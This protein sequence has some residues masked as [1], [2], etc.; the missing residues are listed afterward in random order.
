MSFL[1]TMAPAGSMSNG[2]EK[3]VNNAYF[4]E[5]AHLRPSGCGKSTLPRMVR[6]TLGSR[7]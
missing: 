4:A 5:K 7:A 3:D 1:T 6:L 2:N